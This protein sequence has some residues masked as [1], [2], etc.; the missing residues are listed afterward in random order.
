MDNYV[1]ISFIETEEEFKLRFSPTSEHQNSTSFNCDFIRLIFLF[2][3]CNTV[4]NL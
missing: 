1:E 3:M 2:L 4:Q